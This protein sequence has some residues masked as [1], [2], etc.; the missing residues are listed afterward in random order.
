MLNHM[1]GKQFVNLSCYM[2][3]YGSDC[4][5]LSSTDIK[6]METSQRKI[7]KQSLGLN[8]YFRNTNLLQAQNINKVS[9]NIIHNTLSLWNRLFCLK[10]TK[11]LYSY[12]YVDFL[13]TGN[14]YCPMKSPLYVIVDS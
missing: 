9:H 13:Y 8:K 1:C 6:T 11:I 5:N 7:I 4:I 10:S 3:L 2:A 14:T 12:L